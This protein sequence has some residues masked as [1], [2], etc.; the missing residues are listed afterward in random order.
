MTTSAWDSGCDACMPDDADAAWSRVVKLRSIA[1]IVDESHFITGIRR[2]TNC[3]QQ[4]VSV[5]SEQVD[6]ANSD[7][8][9][10]RAI[11]AVKPA[12]VERL[13]ALGPAGFETAFAELPPPSRHLV[14]SWPGG[15][16]AKNYWA[17]GRVCM[18]PHD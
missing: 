9:Q 16:T 8:P 17:S 13:V 15:G 14:R 7:D 6:W 12:D 11:V 2:C 3:G 10:W 18:M 5:F 4:F 1:T